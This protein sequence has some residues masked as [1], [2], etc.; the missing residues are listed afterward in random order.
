MVAA[1]P[2]A[3]PCL[4]EA[5]RVIER[6]SGCSKEYSGIVVGVVQTLPDSDSEISQAF[7]LRTSDGLLTNWLHLDDCTYLPVGC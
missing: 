1:H 5:I 6:F 2:I 7:I 3:L 4:G